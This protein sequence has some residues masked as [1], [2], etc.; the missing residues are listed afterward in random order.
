MVL[1]SS[2]V[3][4]I[5]FDEPERQ[6]FTRSI[7]RDPRRLMSAGNV[8]ECA[9]VTEARRGAQ[10]GREFDLLVYR[11]DVQIVPVDADQV[12]LARSAWRRFGKGRHPA[13]L[14]FGDCFAYAL[15]AASGEPL[16]FKGEDFRHTDIAAV[17]VS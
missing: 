11:A 5:L 1:D 2:A 7:E 16:L 12:E 14:N 17:G 15:S 6:M 8:L 13:G 10:A 3:L 9:L 4:A